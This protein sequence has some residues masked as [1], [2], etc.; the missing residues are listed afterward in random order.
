MQNVK[1]KLS[2]TKQ[3]RLCSKI[4][5]DE[6]FDKGQKIKSFPFMVTYLPIQKDHQDWDYPVKIVISVPKRRVKL[7]VKRNRLKRQIKEAYRLNKSEFYNK[8]EAKNKNLALFLIYIG[9]E[10]EDYNFIEK[11]LKLLLTNIESKL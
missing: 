5:I 6:I 7:A 2:F 8:L 11:K 4:L 3:E 1:E 10:N 9:K